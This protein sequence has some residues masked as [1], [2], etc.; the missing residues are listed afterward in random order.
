MACGTPKLKLVSC[1]PSL[2]V[3]SV[4]YFPETASR[5]TFKPVDVG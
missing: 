2:S 3:A 4:L 1:E 5:P